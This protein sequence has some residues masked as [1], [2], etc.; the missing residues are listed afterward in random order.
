MKESHPKPSGDEPSPP[1]RRGGDSLSPEA[2]LPPGW[3]R[4]KLGDLCDLVNVNA[5]RD[6]DWSPQGMPVIPRLCIEW[7]YPAARDQPREQWIQ[8]EVDCAKGTAEMV[9]F[10]D[11]RLWDKGPDVGV[12]IDP[13]T[14]NDAAPPE[15]VVV[16]EPTRLPPPPSEPTPPH[17]RGIPDFGAEC[18]P[19]TAR[20]FASLSLDKISQG[21]GSTHTHLRQFEN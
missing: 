14:T 21:T 10:D 17:A 4:V 1:L 15:R 8:V 13:P 18:P 9:R 2:T 20:N 11:V 3:Q 6:T 7:V 5:Y 19:P 16:P 12:P